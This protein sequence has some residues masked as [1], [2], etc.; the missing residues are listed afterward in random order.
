M[1]MT[2]CCCCCFVVVVVVLLLLLPPPP[3]P[4][5]T[6][7]TLWRPSATNLTSGLDREAGE[8]EQGR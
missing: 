5:L 3:L 2:R 6:R 7:S 1:A 8:R 4:A